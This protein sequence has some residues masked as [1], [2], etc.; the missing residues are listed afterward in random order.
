MTPAEE[1]AAAADKLD[2]LTTNVVGGPWTIG[3]YYGDIAGVN[4]AHVANVNTDLADY[5]AA[6]NPLV[7]KALVEML[8][9]EAAEARIYRGPRADHLFRHAL[10]FARL[11]IDGES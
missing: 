10:R 4:G 6:M 1:L 7:G 8:R 11:I 2:A 3:E 9:E 5:I